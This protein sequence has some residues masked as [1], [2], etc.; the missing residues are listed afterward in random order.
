MASI[1]ARCTC[2]QSWD[3]HTAQ[4]IALE[5]NEMLDM[6][7]IPFVMAT[8]PALSR[9]LGRGKPDEPAK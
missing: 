6:V 8:T 3:G 5:L 1:K 7:R 2:Q 4:L 9:R